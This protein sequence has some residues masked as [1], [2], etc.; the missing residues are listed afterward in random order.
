MP[1]GEKLGRP[2]EM[3]SLLS[4]RPRKDE[5]MLEPHERLT[6]ASAR[7]Y[8]NATSSASSGVAYHTPGYGHARRYT[9]ASSSAHAAAPALAPPTTASTSSSRHHPTGTSTNRSSSSHSGHSG[10]SSHTSQ[11][12]PVVKYERLTRAPLSSPP[13]V[14]YERLTT[15][16]AVASAPL[17]TAGSHSP[18]PLDYGL[19]AREAAFPSPDLVPVAAVGSRAF[20]SAPAAVLASLPSPGML[21][22]L[23]LGVSASG[24]PSPVPE[25]AVRGVRPPRATTTTAAAAAK[26]PTTTTTTSLSSSSSSVSAAPFSSVMEEWMSQLSTPTPDVTLLPSPFDFNKDTPTPM[27]TNSMDLRR[28]QDA[29]LPT[30]PP[31]VHDQRQHP[32]TSAYVTTRGP[33]PLLEDIASLCRDLNSQDVFG[34]AKGRV[35]TASGPLEVKYTSVSARPP[36]TREESSA[37][38]FADDAGD[39]Q[40]QMLAAATA[41]SS[42]S[43]LNGSGT[44]PLSAAAACAYAFGAKHKRRKICTA[45]GCQN[46]SRSRGLCKA[47]GGGRR[48]SVDGCSRASQ[49]GSLCI[50]HGGGKRCTVEGCLKAAQS[51][52]MCKAHGGGVRCRVD[53]CAKSSQ[54]DGF[55]R[56]HGGGRRCG[57]PSGCSKWAQRNGMCMAH[58]EGKYGNSYRG[59]QH[60]LEKGEPGFM[61]QT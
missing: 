48:C 16:T 5:S 47:H 36:R 37:G 54:G 8:A 17:S 15:A 50:T 53:G 40:A 32:K 42:V 21:T 20:R 28:L 12:Y 13:V 18:S 31:D 61:Q 4:R 41:L 22:P 49:S 3:L 38:G 7:A 27:D 35:P 55:C 46:L 57:H 58:S 14:Q 34:A 43:A 19:V 1:F 10:H 51:R 6:G 33:R 39:G 52:G 24:R 23:P 59:R 9:S 44:S 45:A 56:S 26:G 25:S 30:P 2:F 29:L 60:R 11:F